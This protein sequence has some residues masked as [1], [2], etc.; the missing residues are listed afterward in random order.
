MDDQQIIDNAF[1]ERFKGYDALFQ[2][3]DERLAKSPEGERRA[4]YLKAQDLVMHEVLKS[5]IADMKRKL[6]NELALRANT[7]LDR[8]GYRMTLIALQDFEN[9]LSALASRYSVKP[10][11]DFANKL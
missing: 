3:A 2:S 6:Y 8:Q 7:E 5:E 11:E 10:L 1:Y 4:Y 9:R